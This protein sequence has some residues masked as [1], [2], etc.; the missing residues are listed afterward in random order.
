MCITRLS[1][2]MIPFRQMNSTPSICETVAKR[3]LFALAPY[4]LEVQSVYGQF[5][6]DRDPCSSGQVLSCLQNA[7]FHP[8]VPRTR[9]LSIALPNRQQLEAWN[10]IIWWHCENW[11]DTCAA[12]LLECGDFSKTQWWKSSI[13]S[14]EP[15]RGKC[16]YAVNLRWKNVYLDQD[17]SSNNFHV[18]PVY[19]IRF[20]HVWPKW[21]ILKVGGS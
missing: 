1:L 8:L 9:L 14:L 4:S 6:M 3:Y 18:S 19:L 15:H 17:P 10:D 2:P 11:N 7:D 5:H 21:N 16:L 20:E 13:E 12:V